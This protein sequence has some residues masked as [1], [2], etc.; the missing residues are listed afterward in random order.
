M[1][2]DSD[3]KVIKLDTP[4]AIAT[5]LIQVLSGVAYIYYWNARSYIFKEARLHT[6]IASNYWW[7]NRNFFAA[8]VS[9]IFIVISFLFVAIEILLLVKPGMAKFLQVRFI[10]GVFYLLKGIATLGVSA[11]LGV[12]AGSLEI[13]NGAVLIIIDVFFAVTTGRPLLKIKSKQERNDSGFVQQ[14]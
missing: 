14:V 12:A 10:R 5:M 9:L 3:V 7:I 6:G 8:Y 2:G 4:L 11:D 1:E 13:V